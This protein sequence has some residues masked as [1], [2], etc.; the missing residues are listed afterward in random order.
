MR[1]LETEPIDL[2]ISDMRMP[3][4]DGAQLLEH[5]RVRWPR[6]TRILLTGP[7]DVHSTVSAINRGRVYRHVN[8]PWNDEEVLMPVREAFERQ[9][10]LH[11]KE[12]LEA[13]AT[14]LDS[15]PRKPE[16]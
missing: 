13:L 5:V 4:M 12:R 16:L 10:L 8:K 2:V 1:L 3:E 15:A 6:P 7:A 9:F 14:A 11:E